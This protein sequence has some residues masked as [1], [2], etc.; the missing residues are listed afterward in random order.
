MD[1][2]LKNSQ[3]RQATEN[4][5]SVESLLQNFNQLLLELLSKKD[6][7]ESSKNKTNS[8]NRRG[9]PDKSGVYSFFAECSSN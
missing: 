7:D 5:K 2:K 3:D 8:A 4:G 1:L 6:D 9:D